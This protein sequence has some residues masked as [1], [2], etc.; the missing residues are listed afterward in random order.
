MEVY[1]YLM[2]ISCGDCIEIGN[3][4]WL[5]SDVVVLKGSKISSGCV[6]GYGSLIAS[7]KYNKENMLLIVHPDTAIDTG[8]AWIH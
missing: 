4:V 6:V 3:N 2:V 1:L 7:G 8:V 5:A